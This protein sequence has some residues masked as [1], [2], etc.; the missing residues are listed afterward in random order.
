MNIK[1]PLLASMICMLSLTSFSSHALMTT[2]SLQCL[3]TFYGK[4]S[5]VSDNVRAAAMQSANLTS[6]CK[7][8][9]TAFSAVSQLV[10]NVNELLQISINT[11]GYSNSKNIS[12]DTSITSSINKIIS[13]ITSIN[14]LL[15]LSTVQPVSGVSSFGTTLTELQK[16]LNAMLSQQENPASC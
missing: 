1:T 11:M 8:L 9:S 3:G 15:T 2:G 5:T 6:G 16:L 7:E 4:I 10:V 13:S 12:S 14:S